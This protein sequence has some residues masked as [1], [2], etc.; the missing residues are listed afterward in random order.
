MQS[1]VC[2]R[3]LFQLELLLLCS[4]CKHGF[5]VTGVLIAAVIDGRKAVIC[6][7]GLVL[8]FALPRAQKA[9][10]LDLALSLVPSHC[11][12]SW[13]WVP[14]PWPWSWLW[15]KVLGHNPH[16]CIVACNY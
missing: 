15:D 14:S 2:K 16:G 5:F 9:V 13:L 6:H 12:C 4:P 10:S 11:P 1:L 8:V 7:W 3:K